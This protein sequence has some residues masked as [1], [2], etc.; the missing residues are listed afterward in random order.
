VAQEKLRVN[1]LTL[2]KEDHRTVEHLFERWIMVRPEEGPAVKRRL[3]DDMIREL[4]I[5]AAIE[6]QVFYPAVREALPE[7][8]ELVEHSLEEHQEA[9][10]LLAELQGLEPG[11]PGFEERVGTLIVDVREHV[12]EEEGQIFPKLQVAIGEGG[13]ERIGEALERAKKVAPTRPHPHAPARPPMNLLAGTAAGALDR[14]RDEVSGRSGKS[15]ALFVA[16]ATAGLV[17]FVMWRT[18]KRRS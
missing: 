17:L 10:G 8:H 16:L 1:A 4:S 3:V 5:H 18:A 12:E 2:L 9:K 13:L 11:E 7:G 14:A 6:E 15:R